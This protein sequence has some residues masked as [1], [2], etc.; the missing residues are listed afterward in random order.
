MENPRISWV[1]EGK[2][3]ALKLLVTLE[4][5]DDDDD[6]SKCPGKNEKGRSK[7]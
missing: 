5:H 4:E 7:Y 2:N 3:P 6:V 1:Y